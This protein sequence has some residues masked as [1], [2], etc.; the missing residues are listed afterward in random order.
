MDEYIIQGSTLQSIADAIRAKSG[1][2]GPVKVTDFADKITDIQ[3]SGTGKLGFKIITENGIYKASDDSLDGYSEVEV[4]TPIAAGEIIEVEELPTENIKEDIFYKEVGKE[5]ISVGTVDENNQW[6]SNQFILYEILFG[7]KIQIRGYWLKDDTSKLPENLPIPDENTPIIYLAYYEPL[8]IVLQYNFDTS[9]WEEFGEAA[10]ILQGEVPQEAGTYV[11]YQ[12]KDTLYKYKN[13][14]SNVIEKKGNEIF[15]PEYIEEVSQE[16]LLDY[17]SFIEI[18]TVPEYIEGVFSSPV[19][20]LSI[21]YETSSNSF[22]MTDTSSE[23]GY[24]LLGLCAGKITNISQATED[25]LYAVYDIWEEQIIPK[26]RVIKTKNGRYDTTE[27]KE[28]IIDI[29]NESINGKW[30]FNDVP[31]LLNTSS[32]TGNIL[33]AKFTTTY[34]GEVINCVKITYAIDFMDDREM[35]Y[36][37]ENGETIRAI[38]S[39]PA[40]WL[41]EGCR[42]INFGEKAQGNISQE[43]K[44]WFEANAT[45][46]GIYETYEGENAEIPAIIT[47]SQMAVN[48]A[49]IE[50]RYAEENMTWAEWIDSV[51]N[52]IGAIADTTNG[53]VKVSNGP[54]SWY[55]IVL[56]DG[57]TPVKLT[58]VIIADYWYYNIL[59]IIE[60]VSTTNEGETEI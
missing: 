54:D 36:T 11:V 5:L 49:D 13:K 42:T 50:T 37:T 52:T 39:L 27:I 44:E 9:T 31:P 53:Q 15:V 18:E 21:Y 20:Q 17:I 48:Y 1:T 57:T 25:G 33:E 40:Q 28:I 43:W 24:K 46:L 22:L 30:Y 35:I 14:F 19:N 29:P 8:G 26:D 34:Q 12:E 47:F 60:E 10:P 51:F 56:N 4:S 32:I 38:G 2:T 23:T 7:I 41:D 3:G 59:A 6:I 58:D 16:L 45:Y 55:Y